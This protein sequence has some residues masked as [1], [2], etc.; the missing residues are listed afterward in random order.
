MNSLIRWVGMMIC[1][2]ALVGCGGGSDPF[3]SAPNP[4]ATP[5]SPFGTTVP[6]VRSPIAALP[7]PVRH[8]PAGPRVLVLYDDPVDTPYAKLGISYAIFIQNLLGHFDADVQ[9]MSANE[10]RSGVVNQYHTTFYVGWA[11]GMAVPQAFLQDVSSLSPRIVWLRGNLQRLAALE[12]QAFER[13]RGFITVD[14]HWFDEEPSPTGPIPSFFSR[15]FYKNLAFDKMARKHEGSIVADPEMFIT[16]VMDPAK[17]K[18]HAVIGNPATGVTAPY[19][20]QSGKFWFVA[21]LPFT[22]YTARDR[23][24]VFADL[25]HDMLEIDHPPLQRAMIRLED[26]DAR[27]DPNNFKPVVDFLY[28]RNVPFSMAV[29][30]HYKDP[31][32]AQNNGVPA[33]VPLAEATTLRLALDYA[34]ERGGEIIQ[35]GLTHQSDNYKNGYPGTGASGI[36]YEFWD[37]M[38]NAPMAQDS[39]PWAMNRVQLGLRQFLDL[40]YRPVAWETPHYLGAPSVLQAVERVY[41]N[42][43]HRHTYYTS[44]KPNLTPGMG[45]DFEQWQTFPYV[46]ERDRY[47]LRVLPE[48]LGNLQY[49]QFGA[50][51][52]FTGETIIKNAEYAKV[53]RD[54][55][56]SFFFHP[57][58]AGEMTGRR[59]MQDLRDIVQGLEAQGFTWTSPSRLNGQ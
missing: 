32:G 43:Y 29:I 14:S 2:A 42:A 50:D 6:I 39:V 38:R 55:F 19:V 8:A 44:D 22:F 52:E 37:V 34:L 21:D 28:E 31:Y 45:A 49:Y 46:I 56:A 26:I 9:L 11:T 5:S 51:E 1:A 53:V 12:G 59:G 54:G 40:G 30:P 17:A 23:Y 47:G 33:D 7:A 57:F 58:L 36:D 35:H 13:Q 24:L 4:G 48:N 15:V 27:V 3:Y 20:L 10:Y 16:E 25:L 18:V 41:Q